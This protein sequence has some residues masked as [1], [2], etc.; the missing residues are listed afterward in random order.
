MDYHKRVIS[1]RYL[2]D[3]RCKVVNQLTL[4]PLKATNLISLSQCA[5]GDLEIQAIKGTPYT[6]VVGSLMYP[7]VCTCFDIACIVGML[8]RY[9]SNPGMDH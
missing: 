2:K 8:A 6:L 7:Q 5:K 3:L 1:I 9:L 4:L